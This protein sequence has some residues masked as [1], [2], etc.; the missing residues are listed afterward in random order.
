VPLF[1]VVIARD[2]EDAELDAVQPV[3]LFAFSSWAEPPTV[4]RAGSLQSAV[5][6][7]M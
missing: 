4:V 5:V 7:W 1:L 2:L 3:G 6:E